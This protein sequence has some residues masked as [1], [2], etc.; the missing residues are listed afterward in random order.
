MILVNVGCGAWFDPRWINLDGEATAAGV[1]RYDCREKLPFADGSVDVV[2]SSHLIEHLPPAVC[3][4]FVCD[5]HRVLKSGGV[6]RLATPDLEKLAFEYLKNF[7]LACDGDLEARDRHEWLVI[8]LFDQFSRDKSG[9]LML[10]YWKQNPMPSEDYVVERMGQEVKN[11]LNN[12]RSATSENAMSKSGP[13]VSN[14]PG[15]PSEILT[16]ERH[17]WLYDRLSLARLLAKAGF[18]EVEVCSHN[19]SR[20]DDY[21]SYRLDTL[22]NGSIRKPDSFFME[23][24]KRK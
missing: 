11:F 20:I 6:I 9:G 23:G 15:E 14:P 21:E 7:Y 1:R 19:S 3:V 4:D 22:E 12:F 13:D 17:R 16:F 18:E 5:I 24:T 8:E 2:Y 10:D